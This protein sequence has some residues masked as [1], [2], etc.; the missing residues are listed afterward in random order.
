VGFSRFEED[1][2]GSLNGFLFE[3]TSRTLLCGDLFT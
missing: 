2:C 3:E 1:E